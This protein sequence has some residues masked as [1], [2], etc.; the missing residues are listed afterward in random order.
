MPK[1]TPLRFALGLA[2]APAG[3]AAKDCDTI[4]RLE[5]AQTSYALL[6]GALD[7]SF[8]RDLAARLHFDLLTLGP[9]TVRYAIADTPLAEHEPELMLF[10]HNARILSEQAA[11]SSAA[12]AHRFAADPRHQANADQTLR[13]VSAYNCA[14]DE[15]EVE[16]TDVALGA[17]KEGSG[18]GQP[19]FFAQLTRFEDGNAAPV[20][21]AGFAAILT[22]GCAAALAHRYRAQI[23]AFANR[24]RRARR[25]TLCVPLRLRAEADYYNVTTSDI[26][27]SGLKLHGLNRNERVPR[28]R[29]EIEIGQTWYQAKI[30]WKNNLFFG[31]QFAEPLTRREFRRFVRAAGR[32]SGGLRDAKPA[33]AAA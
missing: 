33:A 2:L 20:F 10:L 3:L 19:G 8:R 22:I 16:A 25:V 7:T 11:L 9:A 26:S 21:G 6:A 31:I 29:L 24:R 17:G 5:R 1:L 15:N 32:R 18:S 12:L 28:D 4:A 23:K 13:R 27:R 30:V 14:D